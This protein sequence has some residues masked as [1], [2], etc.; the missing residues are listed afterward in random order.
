MKLRAVTIAIL[1]FASAV[2]L[3]LRGSPQAAPALSPEQ[4]SIW[5]GVYSEQQARRGES[6]Y[7]RECSL[8]HGAKLKGN[9]STPPLSGSDFAADWDGRTVGDLFKKIR[10][11]MPQGE[12][13][14]L[15]PQQDADILAYILSFNKF[16]TGKVDLPAETEPLK[17][18]RFQSAKPVDKDS[19]EEPAQK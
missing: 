9:D 1:A 11:T 5:D 15:N 19:H 3:G 16:P 4:R 18:I 6:L 14:R 8:C 12:P 17:L 7:A 10:L 13:D 2:C